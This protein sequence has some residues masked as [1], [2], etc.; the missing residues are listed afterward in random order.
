VN[1]AELLPF[2]QELQ[3]TDWP[4]HADLF[5]P[6]IGTYDIEAL[7]AR[8]PEFAE[9]YD[10]PDSDC[11]DAR[12]TV[13]QHLLHAFKMPI[14]HLAVFYEGWEGA[15]TQT[16]DGKG[17]GNYRLRDIA[18]EWIKNK[19]LYVDLGAMGAVER[20]AV[21]AIESKRGQL[22]A[23]SEIAVYCSPD[24]VIENMYTPGSVGMMHGPSNIGK[25]F[26][27]WYQALCI[28]EGWKY[29]G[30]NVE[31]SGVLYCYGEGHSGM[32]NRALA[33]KLKYGP[34]T[35]N[36]IVRD[37]I[38]NFATDPKGA[39]RA[40][41]KAIKEAN[42]QLESKALRPLKTVFLD[43]FAKAVAGAE[44]NSTREMQPIMNALRE[45]ALEMGVCIIIIH[46]SGKNAGN[47]ARGSSA[48]FADVDFNIEIVDPASSDG[49]RR[50]LKAGKG[51]LVMVLPKMR[52]SGKSGI[53]EFR[54]EEVRLGENKWGN[55]VTSMVVVPI[56][57]PAPSDGA[58]MGAVTDDEPGDTADA[59]TAEQNRQDEAKRQ[60]LLVKVR[61]AM[62][63]KG[64]STIVGTEVQAPLAEI[65]RKLKV[66]AELKKDSG[67]NYAR[68]LKLL[69]FRG[70]PAELL[71]DGW[72][73][74][75]PGSGRRPSCLIFSP[76]R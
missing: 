23:L 5:D 24:Y 7:K 52:D 1:E 66:L 33:Y 36:L 48:I 34:K 12:W 14:I 47:G 71:D 18:R 19:D 41:R 72:L 20:E 8:N 46:H 56:E 3:E 45:I 39:K 69:L 27:A 22:H 25:T 73:R 54:L 67:T 58:A 70:E 6:T 44:E 13:A 17:S 10:S 4:D 62:S 50:K 21:A 51:N 76:K 42:A 32:Q 26:S 9:A 64:V 37:G 74:F 40:L 68:E 30:R 28:A 49:K 75:R 53:A 55:P 63:E 29:F 35:D 57:Q 16:D 11:S 59:L 2:I 43:T 15:G 65:E 60:A 61:A 31:Q 38:P